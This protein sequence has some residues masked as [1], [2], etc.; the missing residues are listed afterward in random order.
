M[1]RGRP[2]SKSALEEQIPPPCICCSYFLRHHATSSSRTACTLVLHVGNGAGDRVMPFIHRILKGR[3]L[4]FLSALASILSQNP[5]GT[6][7]EGPLGLPYMRPDPAC[8][9]FT[10]SVV[11]V[12]RLFMVPSFAWLNIV[13]GCN[14]RV[15]KSHERPGSCEAVRKHVPKHSW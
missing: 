10:S 14:T 7:S 8:R 11:E 1:A 5:H 15:G 13:Q 3:H 6:P 2:G 4:V 9:T 12:S